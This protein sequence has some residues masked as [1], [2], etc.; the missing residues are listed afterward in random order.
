VLALA[1]HRANDR[2][3]DAHLP[4][5]QN[6]DVIRLRSRSRVTNERQLHVHQVTDIA[7]FTAAFVNPV[8]HP[9]RHIY[10][11]QECTDLPH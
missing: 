5:A 11:G 1:A 2:P 10:H 7:G 3:D 6:I 4:I 8:T 9:N